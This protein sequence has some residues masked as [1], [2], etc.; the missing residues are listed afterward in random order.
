MQDYA[1]D[2]IV[3]DIRDAMLDVYILAA[4]EAQNVLTGQR[5]WLITVNVM[6]AVTGTM[7]T[8][9]DKLKEGVPTSAYK[10]ENVSLGELLVVRIAYFRGYLET[11]SGKLKGKKG[12]EGPSHLEG[13]QDLNSG[14]RA[15]INSKNL[16]FPSSGVQLSSTKNAGA[17]SSA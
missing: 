7:D 8:A 10:E 17:A 2:K 12:D 15:S 14:A 11:K 5:F 3:E 1:D 4:H 16:P 9:R 6:A 13:F